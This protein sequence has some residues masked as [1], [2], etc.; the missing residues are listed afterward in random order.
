MFAFIRQK[1][2]IYFKSSRTKKTLQLRYSKDFKE[3]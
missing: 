3:R 1:S 2:T